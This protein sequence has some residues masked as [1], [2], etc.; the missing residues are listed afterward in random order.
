MGLQ[1]F[2]PAEKNLPSANLEFVGLHSSA[3]CHL[4]VYKKLVGFLVP[5]FLHN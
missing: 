3:H 4:D 2:K 5:L 1:L